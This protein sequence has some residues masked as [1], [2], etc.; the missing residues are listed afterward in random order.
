MHRSEQHRYWAA[1]RHIRKHRIDAPRCRYQYGQDNNICTKKLVNARSLLPVLPVLL[2]AA[3]VERGPGPPAPVVTSQGFDIS[4]PR[5]ALPGSLG[6][7]RIRFEV[8]GKI[9]SIGITQGAFHT[10]LATTLDKDE[11]RLFGLEQRPYSMSDVT[12]N[13]RNYVNERLTV[14]G[15]YPFDISVTD[16]QGR[17]TRARILIDIRAIAI[18]MASPATDVVDEPVRTGVFV[19]QRVG[20]GEVSGASPFGF[21]W[22]TIDPVYVTIRLEVDPGSGTRIATLDD[23]DFDGV[24]S[25]DELVNTVDRCNAGDMIELDTA[26]AAAAGQVIA[27]RN[28]DERFLLQAS[29]S[30]TYLTDAGT[31]VVVTGRYK[32]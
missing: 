9:E 19:L 23:V 29:A 26:N 3:C 27:V 12:V 11:F 15:I 31:T 22:K 28:E 25:V 16:R 6:D 30:Q 14:E 32:H 5:D 21:T 17:T 2:L 18:S 13:L 8:P 1:A 20:A 10:D 24:L 7:V 4:E